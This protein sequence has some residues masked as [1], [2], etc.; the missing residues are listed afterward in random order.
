MDTQQKYNEAEYFLGMMKENI[1]D[2][3]KFKYN[4]SAFVSTARSVTLVLQKEFKTKNPDFNKG[5]STKKQMLKDE[6]FKFFNKKRI[7]VIHRE[8]SIDPRAEISENIDFGGAASFSVESEVRD[9]KGNLKD[10]E[11]SEQHNKLNP[12]SKPNSKEETKYK[13]FFK[14]WSDTDEDVITLCERYLKEL[15]II[16]EEAESKFG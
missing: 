16:V 5:Y 15:K 9:A 7:I 13:W 6:L 1:E 11:Y 3:Q 8:G 4:F 12:A 14:D 2:R 10:Y